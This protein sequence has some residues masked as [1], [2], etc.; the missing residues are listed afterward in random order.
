MADG[1]P[2][3]GMP[4]LVTAELP[5]DVLAWADALRRAHYPSERNRLQAH[6]TLFHGLPPSLGEEL[7]QLLGET[8]RKAVAPEASVTGIMDLDRGT[9]L[10]V[11]SPGMQALHARLAEHLHGSIQQRD[12]RELRLHI[13][14]QNKVSRA[15]AVAVQRDLAGSF[16]PR[17]FRFRGFGLYRWDGRLWN[18]SRLFSFRGAPAGS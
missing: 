15:E 8:S 10:A 4:L 14:V 7:R 3:R 9:A 1:K 16:E 18:F 17:S 5:D 2:V 11:E 6:V 13:T 12:A